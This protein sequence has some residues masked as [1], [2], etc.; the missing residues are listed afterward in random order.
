MAHHER[1]LYHSANGDRWL[2]VRDGDSDEVFVTHR[3]NASSGG[4]E[5]NI[6]LGAFLSQGGHGPQHQALLQLIGSLVKGPSHA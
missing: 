3:P 5:S 6:E 4:R 1:E 2:L